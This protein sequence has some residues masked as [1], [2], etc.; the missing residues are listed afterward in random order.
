MALSATAASDG[1]ILLGEPLCDP[2]LDPA[3]GDGR[4]LVRADEVADVYVEVVA[5]AVVAVEAINGGEQ[6][7]VTFIRESP[8]VARAPCAARFAHL[9]RRARGSSRCGVCVDASAVGKGLHFYRLGSAD[10]GRR[11]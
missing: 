8:A 7:P 11:I 2:A 10:L 6:L 3:P 5:G 1:Y 4:H 9:R